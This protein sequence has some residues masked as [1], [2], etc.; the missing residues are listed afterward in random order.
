MAHHDSDPS[1]YESSSIVV[2]YESKWK[3]FKFLSDLVTSTD[4]DGD[5]AYFWAKDYEVPPSILQ[6]IIFESSVDGE[7]WQECIPIKGDR[8]SAYF[9]SK[10]Y[11]EAIA[12]FYS[13]VSWVGLDAKEEKT[14]R[15]LIPNE[16]LI[17]LLQP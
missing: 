13:P 8:S 9:P 12:G 7:N 3:D 14:L 1:I 11:A 4:Y 16:I 10:A 5:H 6:K 17:R 15:A 2:V